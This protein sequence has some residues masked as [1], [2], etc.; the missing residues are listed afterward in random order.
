MLDSV[1]QRL[2]RVSER[3]PKRAFSWT[4]R[5]RFHCAS[6]VRADLGE[7]RLG[8]WFPGFAD[9]EALSWHLRIWRAACAAGSGRNRHSTPCRAWCRQPSVQQ[10]QTLRAVAPAGPPEDSSSGAG[11]AE[12]VSEEGRKAPARSSARTC[13]GMRQRNGGWINRFSTG[14]LMRNFVQPVPLGASRCYL[15]ERLYSTLTARMAVPAGHRVRECGPGL[16][17]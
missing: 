1:L 12:K 16:S 6:T 8:Q 3:C 13:G 14:K 17:L 10:A 5:E 15:L 7:R 11:N 4:S 2:V 9:T